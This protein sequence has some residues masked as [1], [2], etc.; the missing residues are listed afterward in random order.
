MGL[1]AGMPVTDIVVDQVQ[2]SG[3]F[4]ISGRRSDA[5]GDV[6]VSDSDGL[7]SDSAIKS[8]EHVDDIQ[9]ELRTIIGE[10]NELLL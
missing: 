6:S 5:L 2:L 4:C 10:L 1:N 9:Q 3:L 7:S 8:M